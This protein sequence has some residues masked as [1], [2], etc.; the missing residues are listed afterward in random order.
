MLKNIALVAHNKMKPAL[1][2]FLQER[3]DWLWGRHLLATGLT[4]DFLDNSDFECT[5]EHLSA[6]KDGG[7]TELTQR[8][9]SGEVQMVF[10]FRDP[11][12][13]QDYEEEIMAF[14]KACNRVN[15]PLATNPASADL[16]ILGT[17]T[18]E[19]AARVKSRS[20]LS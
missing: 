8:V 1:V 3:K 17:I 20:A 12:I 15:I 18:K 6:G 11:E 10:Y 4:A 16:L 5:V 7:Y 9:N 2:A 14:V 19:S 13:V